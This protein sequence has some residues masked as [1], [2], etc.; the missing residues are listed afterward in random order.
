MLSHGEKKNSGEVSKDTLN[1]GIYI[2][3]NCKSIIHTANMKPK[4]QMK[5]RPSK[6]E[7]PTKFMINLSHPK[8]YPLA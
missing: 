4:P 8:L 7:P 2:K 1:Y 3:L 5:P 6:T